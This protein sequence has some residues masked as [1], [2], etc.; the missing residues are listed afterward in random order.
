MH[1]FSIAESIVDAVLAEL[2][3]LQ[4]RPLRLLSAQIAVGAM[5]QVVPETLE[6]AYETLTAETPAKGSRLKMR[7]VPVTAECG[8]CGWQGSIEPPVFLCPSCQGGDLNILTGKELCLE[9]LEI[10]QND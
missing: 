9:N 7:T 3:R 1:E 10:E 6:F 2:E 8:G 4:P 5:R